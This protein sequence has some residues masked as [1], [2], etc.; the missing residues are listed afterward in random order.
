MDTIDHY[1]DQHQDY[2]DG[3]IRSQ[4]ALIDLLTDLRHAAEEDGLDVDAALI[5]SEIHFREERS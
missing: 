5:M 2:E 3:L 1:M 4:E